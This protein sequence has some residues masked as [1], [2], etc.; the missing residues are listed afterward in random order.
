MNEYFCPK[1]LNEALDLLDKYREKAVIV[2]GGTDIVEKI[3]HKTIDPEVIIYIQEIPEIKS[4]AEDDGFVSIGGASTYEDVLASPLCKQF[5]GLRQ[6]VAQIGSPA[7]RILGTPAGN[8]G[9]A[10]PA[11]DCNVPLIAL[12]A[13]IVLVSKH[14][15]RIIQ[16][17]DMFV[18][19]CKTALERHELIKE[20]RIPKLSTSTGTAFVR[21]TKRKGQDIS[22][23]AVAVCLTLEGDICRAISIGMGAISATTIKA[24]SL[25]KIVI[26]KPIEEGLAEIKGVIPS[27]AMLRSPRNKLY[28]EEVI[29][30]VVERAIKMAYEE[31]ARRGN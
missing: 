9:T 14:G 27:E 5:S 12:N 8:I 22:Q 4:I 31:A 20:I 21:L 2:N 28:K 10:V 18:D 16:A 1:T 17:K 25:E 11:A 23:V 19:Y 3:A 29:S 13:E 7:I 30:V 6:A 24:Y 26:G 15:E